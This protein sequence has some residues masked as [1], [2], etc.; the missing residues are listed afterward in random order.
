MLHMHV[1]AVRLLAVSGPTWSRFTLQLLR[2][3][4]TRAVRCITGA[5]LAGQV[6]LV[7]VTDPARLLA[8]GGVPAV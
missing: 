7:A 1:D 2:A 4:R 8:A 6:R 5:A 3:R